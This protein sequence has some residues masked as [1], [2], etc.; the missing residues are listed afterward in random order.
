MHLPPDDEPSDA[1]RLPN[2]ENLKWLTVAKTVRQKNIE[3]FALMQRKNLGKE[4]RM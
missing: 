2:H 4:A 3:S 1:L